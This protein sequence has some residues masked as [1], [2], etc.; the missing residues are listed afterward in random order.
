MFAYLHKK[1]MRAYD[2]VA[3]E[4]DSLNMLE[5]AVTLVNREQ[6]FKKC[7]LG[8]IQYYTLYPHARCANTRAIFYFKCCTFQAEIV[9][10][11]HF[12]ISQFCCLINSFYIY[13]LK[14]S[15]F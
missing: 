11:L 9:I 3:K 14:L 12:N 4:K 10:L 15:C 8:Y 6:Y 5:K 2:F 1:F 7:N 13:P